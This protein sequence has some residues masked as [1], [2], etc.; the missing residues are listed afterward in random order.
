MH[1]DL[2]K[3]YAEKLI[4]KKFGRLLVLS[5]HSIKYKKDWTHWENH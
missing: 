4:G 5:E 1:K 2:A 3:K